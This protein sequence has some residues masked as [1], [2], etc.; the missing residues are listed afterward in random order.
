M[1]NTES[2]FEDRLNAAKRRLI[3]D[4]TEWYE[5][6]MKREFEI[7]KTRTS[8]SV[9]LSTY[10]V[11]SILSGLEEN[12]LARSRKATLALMEFAGTFNTYADYSEIYFEYSTRNTL[13]LEREE[14]NYG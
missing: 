2:T 1:T 6:T 3:Q 10:L 7:F 11:A 13:P 4:Y 14:P 9:I 5:S 8:R 12:G